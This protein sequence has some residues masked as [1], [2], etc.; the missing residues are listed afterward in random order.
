MRGDTVLA[1]E[2][3]EYIVALVDQQGVVYTKE[4]ANM[5]SVAETTI[6]RDCEELEKQ[7]KLLR[8]H[9]G[10]KSIHKKSILS[11]GEELAMNERVSL[12]AIAKDLICRQAATRITDGDCIFLDGGTTIY[13]LLPYIQKK[14]IKIVTNNQLLLPKIDE[15]FVP[16]IIFIGGQYVS[17]YN[18]TIGARSIDDI[19]KYNFDHAF[20]GCTGFSF[21]N[22]CLYTAEIDTLATKEI[23]IQ[24]SLHIHL[25][26]DASKYKL[27]G[28]CSMNDIHQFTSIISNQDPVFDGE[29]LSSNVTL[30][31]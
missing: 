2:R 24:K 3:F 10:A 12:R 20:L 1:S 18:M 8:V 7:G 28:F 5:L 11:S 14:K 4:L 23:A 13:Y 16:E 31:D 9:G 15:E 30:V 22:D 25:L 21:E 27:R 17:K 29:E 6:R 19:S 26:V